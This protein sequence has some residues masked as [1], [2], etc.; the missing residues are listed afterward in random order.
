MR[1]IRRFELDADH[2]VA[3][4]VVAACAL[5]VEAGRV[6]LTIDQDSTDYWLAHGERVVLAR[7]LSIWLSADGGGARVK[8]ID[9]RPEQYRKPS[10]PWTGSRRAAP[11][12]YANVVDR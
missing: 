1:E 4:R 10:R 2:C 3:R 5:E 6:W 9:L 12:A 11:G 8:I 7:G